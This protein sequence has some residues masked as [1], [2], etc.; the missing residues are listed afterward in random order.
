MASRTTERVYAHHMLREIYEQPQAL[1][2]TLDHYVGGDALNERWFAPVYQ[3]FRDHHQVVF[4][5]S[6]S[7]RHASLAGEIMLEDVSGMPVD[8]EYASEYIYREVNT[9]SDPGIIVVSQ[10]GETADT[11]A[12]LR[13]AKRR[14][15]GTIAVTNV[16]SSTMAR[17]AEISLPTLAGREL[18]VPA[19]KSFTAQLL[20]LNLIAVA[21]GIALKTLAD[22]TLAAHF[23]D[24]AALPELIAS[25]LEGWEAQMQQIA[26]AL[27][28]TETYLYIGRSIHYAIA[29][30]GA[31]KLKESAYL[32][33]EGYPS[34]ELKHGPN[35]LVGARAAVLAIATVDR[36]EPGSVVRYEKSL[37]LLHDLQKQGATVI[38]LGNTGDDAVAKATTHFVPVAPTREHL[39]PIAE[40]IPL[41][42]LAYFS[43]IQRGIDVDRPRNLTKAVLAE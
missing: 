15:H 26:A 33:A 38:A 10:S 35:A 29:R 20:V 7:S 40:V 42:F 18:A 17:E 32:Q 43:A 31:L 14:R 39:L 4:S 25:Q 3:W 28:E 5:A 41:Q 37:Q 21:S 34:G 8:V 12:A 24:L 2:A 23:R 1:A 6:G 22:E 13:E 19:T 11:L 9:L 36:N 30:E 27:L 16:E